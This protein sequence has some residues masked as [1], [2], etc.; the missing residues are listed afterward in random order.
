MA[1]ELH[2]RGEGGNFRVADEANGL[3]V[4]LPGNEIAIAPRLIRSSHSKVVAAAGNYDANDVVSDSATEASATPWLFRDM[5]VGDNRPGG[6]YAA[7]LTCSEDDISGSRFRLFLFDKPPAA[8]TVLGDNLAMNVAPED[9][10]GYQTHI[11]FPAAIDVG[12][13]SLSQSV[14]VQYG[15]FTA[16]HLW[17]ILQILDAETDESAGMSISITLH[18]YPI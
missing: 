8:A 1:T 4:R 18:A 2:Y 15:Y 3:P 9:R 11:D 7:T 16:D 17:G 14:G 13:F 10:I 5:A 6:I 12:G